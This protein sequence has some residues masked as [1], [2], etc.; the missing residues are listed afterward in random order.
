MAA[1]VDPF[2]AVVVNMADVLSVHREKPAGSCP[3]AEC[4]L[5]T[6]YGKDF[7]GRCV[8][9]QA[10]KKRQRR[11]DRRAG[12]AAAADYYSMILRRAELAAVAGVIYNIG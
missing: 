5:T 3:T 1:I 4:Q 7:N 10:A 9:C 2:M 12:V 8:G 6:F 11:A